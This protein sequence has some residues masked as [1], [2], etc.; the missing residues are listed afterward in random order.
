MILNLDRTKEYR[1]LLLMIIGS[2]KR[3]PKEFR[4][5]SFERLMDLDRRYIARLKAKAQAHSLM[6]AAAIQAMNAHE[7]AGL[8]C[9]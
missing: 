1:N 7:K 2:P 9:H 5:Q 4:T 6:A 8:P 3:F